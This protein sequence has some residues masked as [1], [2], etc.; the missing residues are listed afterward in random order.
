MAQVIIRRDDGTEEVVRNVKDNF[1]RGDL[2]FSEDYFAKVLWT[3]EDIANTLEEE[4]YA[5]SMENTLAVLE[6]I[7]TEG[8][9]DRLED[10]SDGFGIISN[11][12]S[13]LQAKLVSK[14][15]QEDIADCLLD[16]N[17]EDSAENIKTVV[18]ELRKNGTFEKVEDGFDSYDTIRD[19]ITTVKGNLTECSPLPK[20]KKKDDPER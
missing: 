13:T 2:L 9:V 11:A 15:M 17:Y 6:K 4:G 16:N 18:A 19:V 20:V 5:P 10:C 14:E 8:S 3:M 1:Y 7:R 12:I